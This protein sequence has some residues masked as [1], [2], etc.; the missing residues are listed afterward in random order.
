MDNLEQTTG[1]TPE[2]RSVLLWMP[3]AMLFILAVLRLENYKDLEWAFY[4]E[5]EL[6]SAIAAIFFIW[7]AGR[8]YHGLRCATM[9]RLMIPG[10]AATLHM[11]L[12]GNMLWVGGLMLTMFFGR[13]ALTGMVGKTFYMRW[14]AI[15]LA[16]LGV[17][18]TYSGE[19][20]GS[21]ALALAILCWQ[22]TRIQRLSGV[23]LSCWG[24][25][26][27]FAMA[28]DL[29]V[30]G[31]EE[32]TTLLYLAGCVTLLAIVLKIRGVVK[33]RNAGRVE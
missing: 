30:H 8:P 13:Y 24:A 3:L 26:S 20:G 4:Q 33:K 11:L 2:K 5:V 29:A 9:R 32:W 25:A 17:S 15:G 7:L 21:L 6:G 18:M 31:D 27:L 19:S 14:A 22:A 12:D 28:G 10:G 23:F 16:L 1:M